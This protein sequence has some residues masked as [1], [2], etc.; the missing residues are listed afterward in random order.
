MA[1]SAFLRS[2][3]AASA[4][5]MG[6]EFLAP[7]Q[8]W[9]ALRN[10]LQ[11]TARA[12]SRETL[13]L[14]LSAAAAQH[15]SEPSARSIAL[16][17][18]G[19][20]RSLDALAAAGYA[21]SDI[22]IDPMKPV[23]ATF[24]SFMEQN[25]LAISQEIDRALAAGTAKA[26]PLYTDLLIAGFDSRHWPVWNLLRAAVQSS[27][28]ALVCLAEPRSA[29][30]MMDQVWI[31]AWENAF[32]EAE[33]LS[34][35]SPRPLAALTA[36]VESGTR[37][38]GADVSFAVGNTV[39]DEAR[40][41]T[42][43]A[44]VFLSR[45]DCTR[46]G[47][48]LP[49][50]GPLARRITR[51][52]EKCGIP[53]H[54]AVGHPDVADVAETTWRAWLDFQS[55]PCVNRFLDLVRLAPEA[56]SGR[57]TDADRI[58]RLLLRAQDEVLVD[59]PFVLAAHSGWSAMRRDNILLPP[60]A[61][62]FSFVDATTRILEPLASLS[63]GIRLAAISGDARMFGRKWK[64][65]F[66]RAIFLRWLE[67]ICS[68]SGRTRSPHGNHLFSRVHVLP[69][70]GAE[71]QAWSHLILAGLNRDCWPPEYRDQQ[72]LDQDRVDSLNRSAL[73]TGSDGAGQKT[74]KAG[75]GMIIGPA[76]RS[77][78]LHR[79]FYNII[80]SASHAV[81]L[82]AARTDPNDA[83]RRWNPSELLVRVPAAATGAGLSDEAIDRLQEETAAWVSKCKLP[84]DADDGKTD[85]EVAAT[86]EAFRMRRDPSKPFGQYDNSLAADAQ[87]V[88][89]S[90]TQWE[91]AVSCPELVF[92]EH[93]LGVTDS[94]FSA[95]DMAWQKTLGIRAHRW[96]SHAMRGEARTWGPLPSAQT[97]K[98][99]LV[100]VRNDARR[101]M[102]DAFAAA[103][104]PVPEWWPLM[105][106]QAV[107]ASD[108]LAAEV[109][110][111]LNSGS[112][113]EVATEYPLD[114]NAVA[115]LPDGAS[116]PLSGVVDI[117][118]RRRSNAE[119]W[120][121]DYKTGARVDFTP[122]K[123]AEG[124]GLQIL[125]YGMALLNAGAETCHLTRANPDQPIE[126][127]HETRTLAAKEPVSATLTVLSGVQRSGVFGTLN[128]PRGEFGVSPVYPL[129]TLTVNPDVLEAR[130][131]LT[132]EK[133]YA[134]RKA[135][136]P[137]S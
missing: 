82:A 57:D 128:N 108:R 15:T 70:D 61:D 38:E 96:L 48:I 85:A 99:R 92:M 40:T 13:H 89:L 80:E 130:R 132:I 122:T 37:H 58:T 77:A 71:S 35:D 21:H 72:Y 137:V 117:A 44:L 101:A 112:W 54:D 93:F 4:G 125:L 36:A 81:C 46:L 19:L 103:G 5:A 136:P 52:L 42:A 113:E 91:R 119:V 22:G 134:K 24:D 79:Q 121:I 20:M 66:P 84:V 7:G 69:Y 10:H 111:I 110:E 109:E 97:F 18:S 116:L 63:P 28:S 68:R 102:E 29:A 6:I 135:R 95:T 131:L 94:S 126:P 87:P 34:E 100:K 27:G 12:A 56:A 39:Q 67:T 127:Q 17:P 86:A 43:Q 14:L 90:C 73:R 2:R 59:D 50:P 47:V 64:T 30:E 114:R 55:D 129:A 120:V 74:V 9:E 133:V 16:D 88:R 60:Q 83:S 41:V 25:G 98:S 49:G 124:E 104:V 23:L 76:E 53:H 1:F 51:L 106:E 8:C 33:L 62:F 123:I 65:V 26:A 78:H 105:F 75:R 115:R 118:F 3:L 31:N 32:G 45:P 11:L 107:S